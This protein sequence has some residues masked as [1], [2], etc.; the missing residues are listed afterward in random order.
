MAK[1]IKIEPLIS[2]TDVVDRLQT[3]VFYLLHGAYVH[4]HVVCMQQLTLHPCPPPPTK[5]FQIQVPHKI[6]ILSNDYIYKKKRIRVY[7]KFWIVNT[8]KS[9]QRW[10]TYKWNM[11]YMW[12]Y[13]QLFNF[14]ENFNLFFTSFN[15]ATEQHIACSLRYSSSLYHLSHY[16][17][18]QKHFSSSILHSVTEYQWISPTKVEHTP[19]FSARQQDRVYILE[20]P[21]FTITTL[22]IWHRTFPTMIM[23]FFLFSQESKI[24]AVYC[25]YNVHKFHTRLTLI[26]T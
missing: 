25:V 4:R 18:G 1:T 6:I 11:L 22:S 23:Y 10:W 9:I 7:F 17:L 12:F 13:K 2:Q 5:K 21:S 14:I 8:Y 3:S 24:W 15:W 20:I 26:T 16:T 19:L